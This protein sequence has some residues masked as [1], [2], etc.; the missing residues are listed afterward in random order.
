M[1]SGSQTLENVW[2]FSVPLHPMLIWWKHIS[3]WNIRNIRHN[4]KAIGSR[5]PEKRKIFQK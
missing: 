1:V 3:F 2:L 5:D 4:G